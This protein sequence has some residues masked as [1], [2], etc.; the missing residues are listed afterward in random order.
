M[1]VYFQVLVGLVSVAFFVFCDYTS[2]RWTE[3]LPRSG[4]MTWRL[5][6]IAALAPAGMIAFG[7][8]G[9]KMGL[10]AVS[11]FINAGIVVASVMVGVVLRNEQLSAWQKVG[12]VLGIVA[13]ALVNVKPNE[14]G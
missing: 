1:S 11:G 2:V 5:V 4:Y 3:E 10:A 9:S 6:C 7:F 8:V 12:I 14:H 13:I